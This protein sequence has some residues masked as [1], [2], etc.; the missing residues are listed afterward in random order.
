MS[1]EKTTEQ[2]NNKTNEAPVAETKPTEPVKVDP[3]TPEA[4]KETEA[5]PEEKKEE[6]AEENPSTPEATKDTEKPAEL[7]R[8]FPDVKPG[9]VVRVHQEITELNPKGEEKKRIQVFEGTVLARKHG[10][11]INSTVIK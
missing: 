10:N 5:K 9:T 3:S 1:D 2:E 7:D 4:T 6:K 8:T 11:E